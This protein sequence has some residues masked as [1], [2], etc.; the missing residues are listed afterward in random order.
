M[1]KPHLR[2]GRSAPCSR[3]KR[4]AQYTSVRTIVGLLLSLTALV[5]QGAP[6][7]AKAGTGVVNGIVVDETDGHAI[8]DV[9]IGVRSGWEVLFPGKTGTDGRFRIRDVTPGTY[10]LDA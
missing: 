4:T 1:L 5:A 2:L 9:A 3:S 7:G 10:F 6:S 8:A